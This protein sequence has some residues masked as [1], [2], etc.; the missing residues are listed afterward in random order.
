M[1][2]NYYKDFSR[3]QMTLSVQGS[4]GCES[5]CPCA[6]PGLCQYSVGI[7]HRNHTLVVPSRPLAMV[8][9]PWGDMLRRGS[10]EM[11]LSLPVLLINSG[12][13]VSHE[14]LSSTI[15]SSLC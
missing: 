11:L 1:L 7:T 10:G 9:R 3:K 13:S 4:T 15:A 2:G 6:R 12:G 8:P 14:G 5:A